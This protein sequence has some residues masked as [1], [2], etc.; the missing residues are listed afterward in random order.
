MTSVTSAWHT[1]RYRWAG[2]A[3]APLPA[4]LPEDVRCSRPRTADH[5]GWPTTTASP[6]TG[7]PAHRALR[8]RRHRAV[9]D[10]RPRTPAVLPAHLVCP[11]P[12]R[13]VVDLPRRLPL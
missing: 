4:R 13:L 3:W 7:R 8:D 5:H 6:R 10:S 9:G 2:S 1:G 12:H 11:R